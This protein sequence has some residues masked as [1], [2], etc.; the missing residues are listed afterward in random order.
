M[1][2]TNNTPRLILNGANDDSIVK[3]VAAPEQL[4]IHLPLMYL[5][6]ERGPVEPALVSGT[7]LVRLYGDKTIAVRDKF[8][9]HATHMASTILAEGNSIL[10]KRIID[11]GAS[12]A[13]LTLLAVVDSTVGVITEYARDVNGN[14]IL[15][16]NLDPTFN[17]GVPVVG[18]KSV[19]WSWVDTTTLANFNVTTVG[20]VS[21]YPVLTITAPSA[22]SYGN[23]VGIRLW[24]A[25]K[26][27]D[28]E[29]IN[30]QLAMMF[31]AQL[32]ERA[33]NNTAVVK[34]DL[35][36]S[37]TQE[38]MFKPGAYDFKTNSNLDIQSVV[39][40]YSDDGT[41]THSSPTFGPVGSIVN[42][43]V[44]LTA[45]LTDLFNVE[46]TLTTTAGVTIPDN[47]NMIDMFTG[48]SY[49]GTAHYG[50][51]I[52]VTGDALTSGRTY[53]ML[54][55]ADG[56]TDNA[57]FNANV[58]MEV[59]TNYQNSAYPLVD[60]AQYPFSVVYDSG[61]DVPTKKKLFK[62]AGYRKDV[63]VIAGTK[64]D[65]AAPLSVSSEISV[66][67]DL[68]ATALLYAESTLHGTATCRIIL[69]AQEG[70][71]VNSVY[72][73]KLG[74][75]FDLASKNAR[76]MGRATGGMRPGLGYDDYPNNVVNKVNNVTNTWLAKTAKDAIWSAGLNF[77]EYVDRYTLFSPAYQTVYPIKGSVLTSAIFAFIVADIEKRIGAVYKRLSGNSKLT[78]Q[79]FIERSNR[80]LLEFTAELYD[81]RVNIVPNTYFTPA[82]NARGYSWTMDVNVYG[83]N[84]RTV[85]TANVIVHR[86]N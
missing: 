83:N 86:L 58:G 49:G 8:Y 16:A 40:A 4:P 23:A 64:V 80:L 85:G 65:G 3:L 31:N 53:Y 22:G 26:T 54:G 47:I 50:F 75:V 38:F 34:E 79:Q 48:I 27:S 46:V 6:T 84:M 43:D 45:L 10:V 59:D 61:F 14:V 68:R 42:H 67:I 82:D 15:D 81:G 13:S 21:T 29:V 56:A 19:K 36:G 20:S 44:N 71:P 35:Y 66:G 18:G 12:T 37:K 63:V 52:D 24:N 41:S 28:T 11:A 5:Q 17:T 7:D 74:L 25:T 78:K 70:D 60:S 57:S 55:G 9:N 77:V 51:Q 62:W 1:A 69:L 30:D 39:T 73:N 76:Y 72:T 32:V 2:I 33:I